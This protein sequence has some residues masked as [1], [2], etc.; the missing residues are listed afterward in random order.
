M[1]RGLICQF[2]DLWF[3]PKQTVPSHKHT[4]LPKESEGLLLIS[5]V[6]YYVKQRT[7]IPSTNFINIVLCRSECTLS[8]QCG[9]PIDK[10]RRWYIPTLISSIT[11]PN[12]EARTVRC[13]ISP[14]ACLPMAKAASRMAARTLNWT[15]CRRVCSS[16]RGE[17]TRPKRIL[18]TFSKVSSR[19]VSY[20]AMVVT[21]INNNEKFFIKIASRLNKTQ[22]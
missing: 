8:S 12:L 11:N 18:L 9:W 17:G 4:P 1:I 3:G 21:T 14:W 2:L 5:S 15:R 22:L 7:R 6:S 10:W 19:S 13:W 20:Q 16:P